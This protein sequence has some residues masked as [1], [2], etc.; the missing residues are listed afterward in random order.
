MGSENSS[1]EGLQREI[2]KKYGAEFMP[3]P[4]HLT[5]GVAL[6][7]REGLSLINGLRHPPEGTATGWFIWAGEEFSEAADFFKP[8]HVQHLDEW[9]PAVKK[10]LGLGPGWRFLIADDYEDVWFDANLLNI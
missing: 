8:L 5:V 7:L 1:L 10:Y 2:C 9:A 4:L 6:N 3:S